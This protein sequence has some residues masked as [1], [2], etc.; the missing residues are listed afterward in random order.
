MNLVD[1]GMELAGERAMKGRRKKAGALVAK[2]W[3]GLTLA[4]TWK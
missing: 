3:E 2:G 4:V 1:P